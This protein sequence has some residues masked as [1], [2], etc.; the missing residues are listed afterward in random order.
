[1]LFILGAILLIATNDLFSSVPSYW[2]LCRVYSP[3]CHPIGLGIGLVGLY[4]G[5]VLNWSVLLAQPKAESDI[6]VGW[7]SVSGSRGPGFDS[8][9]G[10]ILGSAGICGPAARGTYKAGPSS[11][12]QGGGRDSSERFASHKSGILRI[13][14][15]GDRET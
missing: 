5:Y 13:R 7:L 12:K 4:V 10:P 14:E 11:I 9:P 1:M 6:P 2:S 8:G 15:V 3:C